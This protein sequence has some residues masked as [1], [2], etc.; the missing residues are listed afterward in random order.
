MTLRLAALLGYVLMQIL[1]GAWVSRRVRTE[2]DYLLGGRRLGPLL[3]SFS[4]F[5]T[6]FGAE[7]CVGAAGEVFDHGLTAVSSDPFGY[8]LCLLLMGLCVARALWE[9]RVTTLADLFRARF[10]P[11]V[12]RLTAVLI[13]P[14]SL[15]WAA[16]QIRAFGSVLATAGGLPNESGMLIAVLVVVTYTTI[17]G[18]LADAYSDLIQGCVLALGL[19]VLALAAYAS[20]PDLGAALAAGARDAGQAEPALLPA[21][22]DWAVPVLGSLFAQELLMRVSAARSARVAR[23]STIAA[24]CAYTLIGCIPVML[25]LL[26]RSILPGVEHGDQVLPALAGHLLGDVGFVI[27]AGALVAAILSTVD[28]A[29]LACGSLVAHNLLPRG[30]R[31]RSP[32][33]PLRVARASVVLLSIAAYGLAHTRERMAE[34][35][36][37]ASAFGSAGVFVV[38]VAALALPRLGGS[39]SALAALTLGAGSWLY[40]GHVVHSD[41]AYLSS[42]L[43]AAVGYLTVAAFERLRA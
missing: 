33:A 3:V 31:E 42:L 21:L 38:G 22:N 13:I 7:T 32:Q 43:A 20:V 18:L 16:A 35:V 40:F 14:N 39:W 26:G 17:G 30:L 1:I 19:C 25:G 36:E 27:L 4:V 29:L 10:S 37:E 8:G 9:R 24:A 12:E 41:V 23:G 11:A 2:D 6:W 15:L 28:S 5:A 34:L